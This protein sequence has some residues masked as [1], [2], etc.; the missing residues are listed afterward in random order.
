MSIVLASRV[1]GPADAP[2]LVLLNSIGSTT[3]M[4]T[5][6]LAPLIE[7]F[8]VIRIDTR[9][10]GDSPPSP[11]GASVTIADLADDVLATLDSLGL[12]RVA[13]AGLSL[14]G[15][16]AMSM[17]V[18]HPSRVSRVALLCTSAQLGPARLWQDRA[19]A[20]RA[21]GMASIA[22]AV[23]A[24]WLTPGLAARDAS[25]VA[26]LRSMVTS[27]DAESYAQC[28]LAIAA[29]DQRADLARVAAPTLVIGGADDP[30]TP[31]EHQQ[32]IA[33]AVPG[34]R[35]E[36]IDDAA[37]VITY[38]Q[39]ARVAALLLDHFR[40]AGTAAA[41]FAVR[42]AVLGDE[43]VSRAAGSPLTQD[44]QQF[45]TRYAW[46]EVW[47]RPELTRRERSIATLS[48][49][50]TLGAEHELR[51]HVLGA[52]NN[53][54]TPTEIVGLLQHLAIYAGMPRANRAVSIAR[55]VLEGL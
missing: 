55:E 22:D 9:G 17:A 32:A 37:H 46:G 51:A 15:M 47:T 19:A 14:G 41:G 1:D 12:E 5:P 48:A 10:H 11:A 35:L 49:L 29:M 16:V 33:T 27:I 18:H 21:D 26:E 13:L 31:P 34:S 45:L 36:I 23:V 38:E 43:Y 53:G 3:E 2:P 7:Q 54:L 40:G 30:A 39:P 8:R 6:V 44:F 24:R 42:R 28:S 50:V 20:V 4:W 25:L 52:I